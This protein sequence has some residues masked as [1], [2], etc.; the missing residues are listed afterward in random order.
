M[1]RFCR[2][3]SDERIPSRTSP[4]MKIGSSKISPIEKIIS[5]TKP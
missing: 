3:V 5:A 2:S 1:R 4:T